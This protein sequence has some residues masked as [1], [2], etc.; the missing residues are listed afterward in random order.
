M[1]TER[2]EGRRGERGREGRGKRGEREGRGGEG[3]GEELFQRFGSE[4]HRI[5]ARPTFFLGRKQKETKETHGTVYNRKNKKV[6]LRKT[7]E[8]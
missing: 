2:G 6:K 5:G 4:K 3:R 1:Q 8:G 7:K